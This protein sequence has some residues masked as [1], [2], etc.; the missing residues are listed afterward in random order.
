MARILVADDEAN[1]AKLLEQMLVRSGH[2]VVTACDGLEVLRK[3][4]TGTI[5]LVVLD[6]VMPNMS[7]L[8][9]IKE[10]QKK[11]PEVKIIAISGGGNTNGPE[12]YLEAAKRLGVNC[13]LFKPFMLSELSSRVNEM[14]RLT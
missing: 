11:Y 12:T 10:M 14:L 2:E 1:L 9:V 8:D 13:C 5:D 3:L 4:A 6:M 7:G